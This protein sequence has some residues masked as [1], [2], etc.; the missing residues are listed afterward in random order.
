MITLSLTPFALA[1]DWPS[2]DGPDP[3][4]V[5]SETGLLK[6]F[7]ADGPKVLWT[8]ETGLGFGGPA[9]RDNQV[10]FLD[11]T[12]PKKSEKA[13]SAALTCSPQGALSLV[14]APRLRFPGSR[15][16]PAVRIT[17]ALGWPIRRFH[18]YGPRHPKVAWQTNTLGAGGKPGMWAL[19]V[20]PLLY[21]SSVIVNTQASAGGLASYDQ[22]T[23]KLFWQA[24]EV[25]SVPYRSPA[26]ITI[27]GSQQLIQCVNDAV[28]P[29][30]P[31]WAR[32][33]GTTTAG[34]APSRSRMSPP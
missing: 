3:N 29:F 18:L 10:F 22:V 5:S 11:R 17:R 32:C 28:L 19:A 30:D 8:I 24:K 23:G 13:S 15:T 2:K 31:T 21:K 25:P 6:S 4:N 1:A 34:S 9:V 26:L 33:S 20:V 16:A 27:G 12:G 7:P 14:Y